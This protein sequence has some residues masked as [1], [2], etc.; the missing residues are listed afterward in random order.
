MYT[1]VHNNPLIYS[2]PTGHFAFLIPLI[3]PALEV[4]VGGGA[5]VGGGIYV[6]KK[7]DD[8]GINIFNKPTVSQQPKVNQGPAVIQ[9]P[10]VVQ[11]KPVVNQQPVIQQKPIVNQQPVIQQKP[12]VNQQPVVNPSP[13]VITSSNG[14]GYTAPNGGGGI[15][16]SIQVGGTTVTFG[17]GGRRDL[18]INLQ[19]VE[20]AIARDI[21]N[22]GLSHAP[23]G[24]LPFQTVVVNGKPI[25]YR[26]YNRG[27]GIVNVGTYTPK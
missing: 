18:G 11:Q 24:Q 5:A 1:Y 20:E 21:A 26:P 17:H 4:I 15:T 2:D 22:R 25:E 8:A 19:Q 10:P 27:N 3:I 7:L 14:N 12:I 13:T 23:V 6:G 9:Q 16:N